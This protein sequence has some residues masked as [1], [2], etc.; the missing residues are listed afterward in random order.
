MKSMV[1]ITR[2]ACATAARQLASAVSLSRQAEALWV[3]RCRPGRSRARR[4]AALSAALARWLSMVSNTTL[5]RGAWVLLDLPAEMGFGIVERL[6][7]DGRHAQVLGK[8]LG[9]AAGF[10][11]HKERDLAQLFFGFGAPSGLV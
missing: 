8:S 9:V 4:S 11:T 7:G 1:T 5:M 10:A 2:S 6:H 3:C